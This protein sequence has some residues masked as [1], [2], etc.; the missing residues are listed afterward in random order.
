MINLTCNHIFA[1][2]TWQCNALP[3]SYRRRMSGIRVNQVSIGF[4][5]YRSF[6]DTT[7]NDTMSL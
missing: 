4:E 7:R 6:F 3:F 2:G 5:C 1:L